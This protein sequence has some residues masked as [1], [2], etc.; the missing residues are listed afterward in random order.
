MPDYALFHLTLQVLTPIHIGSG[1]E[2]LNEYDYAIANKRT[3]RLND[4]ALLDAQ[5]ID[6]GSPEE[7]FKLAERLAQTPPAQLLQPQDYLEGSPFF[8]YV[9]SGTPRARGEGEQLREQLKDPFDQVYLPGSSLKGALR[10]AVAWHAWEK[11]GLKPE[12]SMLKNQRDGKWLP[13]R[14]AAQ[15]LERKLFV[16]ADARRGHEPNFDLWKAVQVSDSQTLPAGESLL[17]INASVLNRSGI[18]RSQIPVEVEAIRPNTTFELSLK[19]DLALFSD[20]A[21]RR[22]MNMPGEDWLAHLPRIARERARVRFLQEI[23]WF[24]PLSNGKR[25]AAVYQQLGAF[26]LAPNQFYVRLGWGGG[27]DD[28]TLGDRLQQDPAFF[29]SAIANFRLARGKHQPNQPFPASRRAAMQT[30]QTPDG[31]RVE[32][33]AV[34]M[35]WALVTLEPARAGSW[36]DLK[37]KP[38]PLLAPSPPAEE[39]QP[40][41][42]LQQKPMPPAKPTTPA[43][44]QAEPGLVKEALKPITSADQVVKKAAQPPIQ[45]IE[46]FSSLPKEGDCFQ[47]VVFGHEGAAALI[48]IPGLDPDSQAYGVIRAEDNPLPGKLKEGQAIR[49]E[50]ISK[51][52]EMKGYWQIQCRRI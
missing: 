8:R 17:L 4:A 27:W 12:M 21:K 51:K 43:A 39:N 37:G 42:A 30:F 45:W 9:L 23:A 31:R 28:K 19:I 32:L 7:A 24:S 20:W 50:V 36:M 29:E 47:G 48:E 46:R 15:N 22:G 13:A 33:A 41:N 38:E 49:C 5:S 6:T 26:P 40:T 52:E 10:T 11:A 16:Q 25:V 1:R 3:W 14:F 44:R 2:L 35:G 18:N 34:P